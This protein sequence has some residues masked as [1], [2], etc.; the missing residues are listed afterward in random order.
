[1][2][3]KTWQG[4]IE[5]LYKYFLAV[6]QPILLYGPMKRNEIISYCER[7]YSELPEDINFGEDILTKYKTT[8][9]NTYIPAMFKLGL[10]RENG[11]NI[12]F[13]DAAKQLL[14]SEVTPLEFFRRQIIEYQY[15]NPYQPEVPDCNLF[16][17]WILLRF[18]RD[19]KTIECEDAIY[20][21]LK[22]DNYSEEKYQSAIS[23][24]T[25]LR[26]I[27]STTPVSNLDT[28]LEVRFGPKNSFDKAWQ[29]ERNYLKW[30]GFSQDGKNKSIILLNNDPSELD[31]IL[32]VYPTYRTYGSKKEYSDFVGRSFNKK[33]KIFFFKQDASLDANISI[34]ENKLILETTRPDN[35]KK[36]DTLLF[37]RTEDNFS[38]KEIWSIDS[39]LQAQNKKTINC[40]K[41]KQFSK[42]IDYDKISSII[43]NS[44]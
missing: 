4:N 42:P 2:D 26:T 20:V 18:L 39:I 32:S 34:T 44:I 15:K 23:D 27:K 12:T 7:S 38:L 10:L 8:C 41:V 21:I 16:T 22:L 24:I 3:W 19:L 6:S 25:E 33:P 28:A 29:Y 14:D 1:M 11:K 30:T 35:I 5:T 43:H 36:N 31:N 13:T 40:T 17:N 37:T 9:N